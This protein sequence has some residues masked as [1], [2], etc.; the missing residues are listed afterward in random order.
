MTRTL[1]VIVLA[2]GQGT[3]MKSALPKVLHRVCG[4]P[5]AG[6][7]L[8]AARELEPHRIAVVVG[9][10]SDQVRTALAGEG[11]TFVEQTELLGTAD[12]VRRCRE[13]MAGCDDVM[14]LNGD[15][16]LIRPELLRELR[17]AR[18]VSDPFAF[19]TCHVD[20]PGRLGRVLRDG[21]GLVER[22]VE[23]A[24]YEGPAG[25]AEVNAGQYV[26]DAA[27]LWAGIVQVPKSA[28]GEYYLTDMV[29][30]AVSGWTPPATIETDAAE[31][32]GVDDRVKLAEAERIMRGR[33]L[34]RHMLAGVTI[35]D[36]AT[37]YIDAA[38]QLETDVTVLPN[39]SL[40]GTATVATGCVI[41]PGTTL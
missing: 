16:P 11:I 3:R 40:W 37:T 9:H 13:A 5:M 20:D 27:R 15:S 1:G 25:P 21:N 7:I 30:I 36:P 12:A 29:A 28:K 2:A 24:D 38:V 17:D 32:L 19:V 31:A 26:F 35:I 14:V 39:S 22:I 4:V 34:E 33:I 6:H 10:G 23:A 41:G 18:S 8:A